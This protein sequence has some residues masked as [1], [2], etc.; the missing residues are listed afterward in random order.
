MVYSEWQIRRLRHRLAAYSAWRKQRRGTGAMEQIASDLLEHFEDSE[1]LSPEM[2]QDDPIKALGEWLRRFLKSI[3][4]T[5]ESHRLDALRAFLHDKG[6]LS[7]IDLDEAQAVRH[8]PYALSE[9]LGQSD[10]DRMALMQVLHRY[11]GV[12]ELLLQS[13]DH[14]ETVVLAL[15]LGE[16]EGLMDVTEQRTIYENAG[17]TAFTRWTEAQRQS[18]FQGRLHA[19]GF[20]VCGPEGPRQLLMRDDADY[21]LICYAVLQQTLQGSP[22]LVQADRLALLRL[23]GQLDDEL[24]ARAEGSLEQGA[25]AAALAPRIMAYAREAGTLPLMS[26][27]LN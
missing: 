24:R 6:F 1:A 2:D 11:D 22:P 18:Y 9:F 15:K 21:R 8:A 12:Y 16:A 23:D 26:G 17:V 5:A 19:S 4:K 20:A 13:R 27:S 7:A 14:I 3:Q 25:L 10:A